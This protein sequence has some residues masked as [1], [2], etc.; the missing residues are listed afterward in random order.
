MSNKPASPPHNRKLGLT[1]TA[2]TRAR[3]PKGDVAA[4]SAVR[5][6]L[7]GIL[8]S[9]GYCEDAPFSWVTIS[10]RFGLKDEEEPH[11][12]A[13]SERYGD[14]PLAIEVSTEA[15]RGAGVEQL[16]RVFRT[17]AL[18]ALIHAGEKYGRPVGQ[19]KALRDSHG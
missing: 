4:L 9:S 5:D 2:L 3:N 6:E 19:L 1:G 14:L 10:I 16:R 18:R 7:E 17:A 11:Y 13:I 8:V 15:I 12:Q